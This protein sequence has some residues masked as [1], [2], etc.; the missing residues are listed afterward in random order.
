[1]SLF[2]DLARIARKGQRALRDAERVVGA[3]EGAVVNLRGVAA[4]IEHTVAV[5]EDGAAQT[6]KVLDTAERAMNRATRP[7][8]IAVTA[9]VSP[10]TPRTRRPSPA[11]A[12]SAADDEVVE[13]EVID[14]GA[15]KPRRRP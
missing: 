9:R 15:A 3:V 2:G 8:P 11:P 14:F 10:S 12:V 1:M 7:A 6:R 5:I 4:G 13:A